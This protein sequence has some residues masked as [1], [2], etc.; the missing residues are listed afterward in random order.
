MWPAGLKLTIERSLL[1][2]GPA[3]ISR[4]F[5]D[6]HAL[7]LA[8]HNIVPPHMTVSGDT[9]LH[10]PLDDFRR[11]LDAIEE[12]CEVVE[13]DDIDDR[14]PGDP[15]CVAL[16]FDDAYRGSLEY[17]GAE[18]ARRKLP[19][20]VFVVPA[21]LGGGA[22]WW[23]RLG[24]TDS[25]G[26]E[27]K[28]REF[29]LSGLAGSDSRARAWAEDN[30]RGWPGVPALMSCPD[31]N[32]L[33]SLAR[34]FNLKLGS[35]TWSHPNLTAVS[36]EPL[37]DELQRSLDWVEQLPL[38]LQSRWLSY[39]YGLYDSRVKEVAKEVGYVGALAIRGGWMPPE[40]DRFGLPRYNVSAGLSTTGFRLRLCGLLA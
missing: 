29:I 17:G 33:V 5:R 37:L 23:D 1:H 15:P 7:I 24:I 21:F 31:G 11:Q 22:F 13:L 18:L 38:G 40:A 19:A 25:G 16:T 39:P 35:H 26:L 20:T 27:P 36:D 14:S 30:G 12:Q 4:R 10:L 8:Y 28:T 32:E 34:T 3:L 6:R 9:P 2:G